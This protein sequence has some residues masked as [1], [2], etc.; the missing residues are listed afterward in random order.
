MKTTISCLLL[1]FFFAGISAQEITTNHTS[2]TNNTES[3]ITTN[4]DTSLSRVTNTIE[5]DVCY[6]ELSK[7]AFYEAL[8]R[9]N[10]L[11]INPN[12]NTNSKL[13]IKTTE[14]M[15]NGNKNR[16]SYSK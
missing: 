2:H 5:K 7:Q 6:G 9:Q 10:N 3:K 4:N 14:D 8:I 15:I 11:K 13:V 16:I 1:T 12:T